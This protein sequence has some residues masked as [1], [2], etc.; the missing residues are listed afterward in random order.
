MS[1][2]FYSF[3]YQ[4][5]HFVALATEIPYDINS[6]QYTFIKNDL[7][8]NSKNPQN[9]WIVIFSYRPQYSS[10][11]KHPGDANLRD[12]YHP[13]FEKYH[14]DVVLQAHNHNYQRTTPLS[15]NQKTPGQP[16]RDD[17]NTKNYD[18][19]KGQIYV[20]VGT[21][22]AKLYS[23]SGK[24]PFVASQYEG[25]GFLKISLTDSGRN[26]TGIY[27]DS[28]GTVKDRFTIIK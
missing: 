21:G 2:E 11:T 26:L 15:Y 25:F 7:E 12:I 18:S 28:A 16:V 6:Q 24:A 8:T 4:N 5:V 1:R 19:P 27:Y 9:K 22:G 23:F 3:D 14:V 13:L 17:N 10:P 20:T